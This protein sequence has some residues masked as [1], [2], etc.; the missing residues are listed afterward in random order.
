MVKWF[1]QKLLILNKLIYLHFH[2]LFLKY[3]L[4]FPLHSHCQLHTKKHKCLTFF[5][6]LP[7]LILA[8][9]PFVGEAKQSAFTHEVEE[10]LFT[11]LDQQP[12][13]WGA[14]H[15][16][17]IRSILCVLCRHYDR[18]PNNRLKMNRFLLPISKLAP[19]FMETCNS[20]GNHD[21]Q[22]SDFDGG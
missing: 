4:V 22:V 9:G 21:E 18:T 12:Q 10:H 17:V 15:I 8:L 14:N 7:T 11:L 6:Y 13:S 3:F 1:I 5:Q 2:Y 20:T 16:F 19:P